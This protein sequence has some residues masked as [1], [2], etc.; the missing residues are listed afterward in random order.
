M[1]AL[2]HVQLVKD[3]SRVELV[4]HLREHEHVEEDTTDDDNVLRKV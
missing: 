4:E 1:Q 2:E 3:R